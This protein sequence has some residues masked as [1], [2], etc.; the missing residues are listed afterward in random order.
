MSEQVQNYILLSLGAAINFPVL[1]LMAT[2]LA[3]PKGLKKS[4][5]LLIGSEIALLIVGVVILILIPHYIGFDLRDKFSQ[6]FDRVLGIIL[7][8]LAIYY[9]FKKPSQ[10]EEKPQKERSDWAFFV[11]GGILTITNL[12]SLVLYISVVKNIFQIT[13]EAFFRFLLLLLSSIIVNIMIIIPLVVAFVSP[14]LIDKVISPVN[15]FIQKYKRQIITS[16]L[17]LLA[18]LLLRS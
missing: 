15:N 9:F 4:T 8:L 1:A 18:I 14:D 10:K 17:A 11:I 13:D 12:N 5:Y 7:L 6:E 2:F 3:Q 16:V